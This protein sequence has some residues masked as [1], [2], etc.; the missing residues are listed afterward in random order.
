MLIIAC[1]GMGFVL[2][3]AF[4][5]AI[6]HFDVL[7]LYGY[8]ESFQKTDIPL[9]SMQHSILLSSSSSVVLSRERVLYRI[10]LLHV[11]SA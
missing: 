6:T 3:T 1:H 7:R 10:T 5:W 8:V 9:L 4:V 11:Q 2:F